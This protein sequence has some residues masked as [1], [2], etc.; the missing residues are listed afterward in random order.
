[1]LILDLLNFSEDLEVLLGVLEVLATDAAD[2]IE[3]SLEGLLSTRNLLHLVSD[4]LLDS[5][6]LIIHVIGLL[7]EL[8]LLGLDL[9]ES[10]SILIVVLLKLLQL[11]ALLE[12]GLRCGTALVFQDLLLFK[13]GTL[14]SLLELVAVV[15]VT[16]LQMI[17][18]VGKGL[19]LFF[20]LSDLAIKLVTIP[21]ELFLLLGCFDHIVGLRVLTHCLNFTGR[22]LRFLDKTL[23]LN[24]QVLDLVLS[25]LELN[26]DFVALLLSGLEFTDEYVLVDLDLLFSLLHAHLQLILSVLK[27]IDAVGLDVHGVS[28]FLDLKLHAIVLHESLLLVLEDLIKVA[29]GHLIL[30]LELLDLRGQGVSLA[31]DLADGALDVAALVCKLLV[32]NS[33][34]LEGFLLLVEFLLDLKNFLLKTLGLLLAALTR[35]TRDLTLHLLNLEL[36]VIEKL[37]LSLLL[38]LQLYDVGLKVS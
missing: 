5:I 33:K 11:T 31:L 38:L 28:Q 3:L 20:T 22:G 15:L 17:Q 16:H 13:I 32:G 29:I 8:L 18:S 34:L 14:G 24:S 35:G 23:I 21:L 1:M 30:E 12:E 4:L 6:S 36:S 9:H 26:S 25:E 2:I 19:D 10:A 7:R 27:T 37:L